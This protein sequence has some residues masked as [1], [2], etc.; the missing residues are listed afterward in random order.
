MLVDKPT[1][2]IFCEDIEMRAV[3]ARKLVFPYCAWSTAE[4]N[5]LHLEA[6]EPPGCRKASFYNG[7]RRNFLHDQGAGAQAWW[8]TRLDF[9]GVL[10]GGVCG[11][12]LKVSHHERL[13]AVVF[14]HQKLVRQKLLGCFLPVVS[15]RLAC[16]LAP[17]F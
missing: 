5:R 16:T 4:L 15:S 2:V 14:L 17:F 3:V 10:V 1:S 11:F 9:G 8:V 7:F 12:S 6:L 13:G